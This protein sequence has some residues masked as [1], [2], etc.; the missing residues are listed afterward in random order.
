MRCLVVRGKLD[1]V[2]TVVGIAV[3]RLGALRIGRSS[4]ISYLYIPE[5]TSEYENRVV[6]IQ[7]DLGYFN[8][9]DW[10][11]IQQG[12]ER[13]SLPCGRRYSL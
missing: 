5:W 8:N 11:Q 10:Q 3:E 1:C 7:A 13:I 4:A 9:V 6:G 12:E 2:T